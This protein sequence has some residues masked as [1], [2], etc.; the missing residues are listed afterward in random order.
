MKIKDITLELDLSLGTAILIAVLLF[1]IFI[2]ALPFW[3]AITT[4]F[5]SVVE[6]ASTSPLAP[7]QS[8]VFG[9]FQ[10]AFKR[11]DRPLLNS[12]Y[13]SVIGTVLA[14]LLGSMLAFVLTHVD[15]PKPNLW[16]ALVLF[17]MN[18]PYQAV[19][20]P[21]LRSLSFLG[22]YNSLNGLILIHASF[23]IPICTL[24]LRSLY[25]YIPTSIIQ[26]A[27][28]EGAS[29]WEIY[30]HIILPLSL[31][32]FAITALIE[33]TGVWNNLLFGL[34]LTKGKNIP[35]TMALN[36]LQGM[37]SQSYNLLMGGSLLVAAPTIII[38]ATMTRYIVRG[39]TRGAV[40]G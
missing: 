24:L 12:L 7:P 16:F 39:Y 9:P 17:G 5:K 10:E 2:I 25:E 35:A 27:K 15:F 1:F 30:R 38:Y 19:L 34:V 8:P 32:P 28:L 4:A 31:L 3:S 18:I 14:V 26:S 22:L 40:V 29:S 37:Y 36:K 11:L 21:V 20:V 6:I 13:F 33:F 23:G